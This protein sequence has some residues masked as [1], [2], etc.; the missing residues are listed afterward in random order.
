MGKDCKK[1]GRYRGRKPSG[2]IK[3]Y[4]WLAGLAVWFGYMWLA[5]RPE[6]QPLRDTVIWNALGKLAISGVILY[7]A[8]FFPGHPPKQGQIIM[9]LMAAVPWQGMILPSQRLLLLHITVLVFWAAGYLLYRMIWKKKNNDTLMFATAFFAIMLLDI[10]GEYV[11]VDG[12]VHHWQISLVL[13]LLAGGAACY[14]MFNGFIR[15]KDDR[16]SEKVCWCIM[17]A[18]ISFFLIWTTVNNLNYMLDASEPE[19]FEAYILDKEIDSSGKS[20]EYEMTVV[21]GDQQIQMDV[22]QSVYFRY[23]IGGTLPVDLYQGFFNHP[24]YINE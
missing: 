2:G 16:I 22:M 8:W 23:E 11:Y 21:I 9:T 24:Y 20:T 14:L 19:H 1:K 4:W 15:L 7:F 18:F 13:A 6:L 12:R 17:A 10:M 5:Y 3:W